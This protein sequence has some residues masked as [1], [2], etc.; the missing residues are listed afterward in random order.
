MFK[1]EALWIFNSVQKCYLLK[2][3]WIQIFTSVSFNILQM[4]QNDNSGYIW[5][6]RS[7]F[8]FSWISQISYKV[9]LYLYHQ[10]KEMLL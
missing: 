7:V 5:V 3:L 4:D 2:V 8:S 6:L 10:E 9:I 1:T